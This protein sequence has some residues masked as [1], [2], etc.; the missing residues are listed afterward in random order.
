MAQVEILVKVENAN[1]LAAVAKACRAA[2]MQI[3]SQ[4]NATAMISGRVEESSINKLEQINGVAY[5][6]KSQ[7]LSI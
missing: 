5:V 7:T 2:G 6:E 1:E 3:D 4:M